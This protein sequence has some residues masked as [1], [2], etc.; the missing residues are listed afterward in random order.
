MKRTLTFLLIVMLPL[1]V[2]AQRGPRFEENRERIEARKVAHITDELDLSPKEA[3]SFWPVYNEF[4]DKREAIVA[5]SRATRRELTKS[6]IDQLTEAEA[7]KM[8]DEQLIHAQQMLD[9]RKTYHTKFLE[10]LPAVKVL[11]LYKAEEDFKRLLL[12][13]LRG[14]RG[15]GQGQGQGRGR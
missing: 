7:R 5:A 4:N 11:K 13:H 6:E 12:D 15:P 14:R 1:I 2:L 8:A 10:V 9:L 3:Q